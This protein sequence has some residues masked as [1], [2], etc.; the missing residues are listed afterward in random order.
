M[1]R[2]PFIRQIIFRS[3]RF[4]LIICAVVLAFF[5]ATNMATGQTL[6]A[7]DYTALARLFAI[8]VQ[9][10]GDSREAYLNYQSRPRLRTT[11][12]HSRVLT[13]DENPN[14]NTSI[15]KILVIVN[16]AIYSQL[17][18]KIERYAYDIN[19]VY[20]CQVIME[21]VTGGEH[22]D[23][24]D[25]ILSNQN[26]LDGAVFIGEIHEAWFEVEN[27]FDEYGYAVWP[28]D[29][30][31]M[32]LNGIWTDSNGNG[33][34]DAF[35][36]NI[37]PEIFVGRISTANMGTLMS[38]AVGLENYLDKNHNFWLG[39]SPVNEKFGLTYTDE[40][41]TYWY[42][43][44]T[45]IQYLY[46]NLS[47]DKVAHGEDYFFGR[48]DYLSRLRN[49]RYGFIQLSCHANHEYLAMTGGGITSNEIFNNG[50]EAIGYNLFSCSACNWT[51][52][53]PYSNQGFLGGT[54][55][56]NANNLSLVAIG[57]T[58][59][60]SML[61][62]NKF[63]IP[64]GQGK[65]MGESLKQWWIDAFGT[66]HTDYVIS[67]HYGMSII[68]DPIINFFHTANNIYTIVPSAGSGGSISPSTV[69]TVNYGDNITFT[70][71]PD[72]DQ[73]VDQWEVN[74]SVVQTSGDT[75]TLENV[76]ADATVN[77]TFK[78]LIGI[79]ENR[80]QKI[81]IYPNPAHDEIFIKS[82]LPIKKVEIYS[83][84]GALLIRE[85]NFAKKISVSTLLKGVY[86]LKIDTENDTFIQKIVKE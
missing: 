52:V 5:G 29:L 16:S 86:I 75:Y 28:C 81:Q 54:H 41:W 27:D 1:A 83:T 60:G 63:Y 17:P 6:T 3:S 57:S 39:L 51:A 32:D 13:L 82:E 19:R 70:A 84:I 33:I 23:I 30:Y 21:T 14:V 80:I 46:G 34:Y 85:D 2:K 7:E 12:S 69:Q 25:L 55:V 4:F 26:N 66:I 78:P 11:F 8:D 47:Y 71:I 53:S 65:T 68:G 67:W 44:K 79:D 24:K 49:D 9:M 77:V 74:G 35:T 59:T 45:D 37:Q 61:N 42:D 31:Y 50:A 10:K 36:G 76:Q 62:F 56:Y 15:Q 64:L 73:E 18:T 40:D 58:K 48:E 43:F 20:G 22:T 72:N 38:E